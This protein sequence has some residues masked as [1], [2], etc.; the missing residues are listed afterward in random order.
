[1]YK[2]SSRKEMALFAVG[3]N[4][5]GLFGEEKLLKIRDGGGWWCQALEAFYGAL[6]L[7]EEINF[8]VVVGAWRNRI[9]SA[10]VD[11]VA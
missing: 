10:D 3:E 9:K 6:G 8:P 2:Y 4:T 11:W 1:M 7:T 5:W